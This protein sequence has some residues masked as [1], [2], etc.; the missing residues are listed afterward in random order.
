MCLDL[1]F[2]LFLHRYGSGGMSTKL[3]TTLYI[4]VSCSFALRDSSDSQSNS[5]IILLTLSVLP[6]LLH[7]YLAA[8]LC[9]D[10]ILCI[11]SLVPGFQIV[12]Q[13]SKCGLTKVLYAFALVCVFGVFKFLLRNPNMQLA[14]FVTLSMCVLQF[15]S[16]LRST[17][18]YFVVCSYSSVCPLSL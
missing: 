10:S 2:R 11:L 17:P 3:L 7:T 14:F 1:K 5:V 12:L 8:L 18:R 6:Y 9:T 13:Y 15:K 4:I 16:L